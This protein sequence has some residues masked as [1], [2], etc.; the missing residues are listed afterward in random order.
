MKFISEII[1]NQLY[2][3]LLQK[4]ENWKCFKESTI[5]GYFSTTKSKS[6]ITPIIIDFQG[7][8]YNIFRRKIEFNQFQV[9]L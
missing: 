4:D 9:T 6:I 8:S 7:V 5:N 3:P 1:N 2:Q